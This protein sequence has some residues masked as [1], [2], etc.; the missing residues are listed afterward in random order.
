MIINIALGILLAFLIIGLLPFILGIGFF[1]IVFTIFIGALFFLFFIAVDSDWSFLSNLNWSLI[2]GILC[3]LISIYILRKLY[4]LK[5]SL[6]FF[7]I[8]LKYRF[9]R[10]STESLVLY[11]KNIQLQKDKIA[12]EEKNKSLKLQEKENKFASR[13][14]SK[15]AKEIKILEE[16]VNSDKVFAFRYSTKINEIIIEPI[17]EYENQFKIAILTYKSE[18]KEYYLYYYYEDKYEDSVYFYNPKIKPI[19]KEL[20]KIIGK[21]LA[22]A[23]TKAKLTLSN[24]IL[25]EIAQEFGYFLSWYEEKHSTT[26]DKETSFEVINKMLKNHKQVSNFTEGDEIAI[27]G[28]AY[29]IDPLRIINARKEDNWDDHIQEFMKKNELDEYI[30]LNKLEH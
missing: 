21:T 16:K 3:I 9:L 24:E 7:R 18:T 25:A 2:F 19:I 12:Q 4:K 28:L 17:I 29:V 20:A 27:L 15:L 14:F 26:F 5:E 13:E 30:L 11:E 23:T 8:Y 1:V 10:F 22:V 6:S